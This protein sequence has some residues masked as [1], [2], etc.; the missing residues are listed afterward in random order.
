M[1]LSDTGLVGMHEELLLNIVS[2]EGI[3]LSA[4]FPAENLIEDIKN[5]AVSYFYSNE[6]TGPG[7]FKIVRVSDATTLHDFLTI[8]QEELSTEEEL[9][10]VERRTPD[11]GMLWDLG[12]VRA[13]PP[14]VIAA[15]TA[16]LPL[17]QNTV[18]QPDL[19]SLLSTN[20]LSFELKKILI[21]LI[22]AGARLAAAGRNYETTLTQLRAALDD[23]KRNP[24][25]G[26]QVIT[27]EYIASRRDISN[28]Q[29]THKIQNELNRGKAKEDDKYK[30]AE[31]LGYF[32]EKFRNWRV[33]VTTP[34]NTEVIE[35]LNELGFSRNEAEE[36]L[37]LTG[38][39][40][41]AAAAWL[42]GERGASIF[43]LMNGLPE[44]I[45]L[46]KVLSEPQIQRG[47][48][49]TRMLLAFIAMVGQ[50]GNANLWLNSPHGSSLL[51][52]I[53]RTYHSEKYCLAVNQFS[54]TNSDHSVPSTS[55]R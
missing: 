19:Q 44:G 3:T 24:Q 41:P 20:D 55:R 51:S 48:L 27:P 30:R 14:G 46:Q 16:T 45:I 36:A 8:S 11:A 50:T 34:P 43:E 2:P 4:Y 32:L 39:S 6:E 54:D 33:K 15:A 49:N 9:L 21:S 17:S 47:L 13:P 18:R 40:V 31:Y 29:E 42:I 37:K 23:Y 26:T 1:L 7:R 10:L 25:R 38:C 12:S 22:E 52:H 5:R 35:A 53:S 28:D